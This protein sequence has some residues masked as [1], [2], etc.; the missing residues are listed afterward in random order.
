[1]AQQL[2]H[3]AQVGAVVQQV[4]REA[5]T[6]RVRA[7]ARVEAGLHEVLVELAA[8]RAGAQRLAVLVQEDAAARAA[9]CSCGVERRASRSTAAAP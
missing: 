6:Q 1:M 3:A 9:V 7:D 8:D 4:R 5:V 2:L